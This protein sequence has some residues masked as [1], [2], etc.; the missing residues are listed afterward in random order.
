M[1]EGMAWG[2]AKP[3]SLRDLTDARWQ[4]ETFPELREIE[5]VGE[6][7]RTTLGRGAKG[8][9]PVLERSL[10]ASEGGKMGNGRDRA[11]R[12]Q[13]QFREAAGMEEERLPLQRCGS[14]RLSGTGAG[15]S[16]DEV[17]VWP[18]WKLSIMLG[19]SGGKR[20]GVP[21]RQG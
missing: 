8:S 9:C 19:C 12:P 2:E 20:V 4:G 7:K 14:S 11:V 10:L 21:G 1:W 17:P 16:R 3:C 5:R 15:P 6:K 13:P 18:G